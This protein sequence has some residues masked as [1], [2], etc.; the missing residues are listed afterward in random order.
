MIDKFKKID[1][2][3]YV[4]TNLSIGRPLVALMQT[5]SVQNR[6]SHAVAMLNALYAGTYLGKILGID[7]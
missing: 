1:A 7:S 6:R 5:L 4:N 2:V 3:G